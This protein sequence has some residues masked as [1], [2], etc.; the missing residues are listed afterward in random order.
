MHDARAYVLPL[1]IRKIGE[2]YVVED[3]N[4]IC[5]TCVYF[6]EEPTRRALVRRHSSADA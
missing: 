5:L 1:C 6:E 3:V 2:S 4:G